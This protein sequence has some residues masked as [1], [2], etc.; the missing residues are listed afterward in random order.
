MPINMYPGNMTWPCWLWFRCR[1]GDVKRKVYYAKTCHDHNEAAI[2]PVVLPQVPSR[3]VLCRV[4]TSRAGRNIRR[5]LFPKRKQFRFL[6]ALG[7]LRY[8]K[9]LS[10][11][12]KPKFD[13][14]NTSK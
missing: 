14:M 2:A 13:R 12:K 1:C 10:S 11:H 3:W 8:F 7:R 6:R 9:T 4:S 5:P